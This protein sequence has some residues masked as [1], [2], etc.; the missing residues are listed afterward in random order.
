M[1]KYPPCLF[2]GMSCEFAD[3]R[4]LE[5]W[6]LSIHEHFA[7]LKSGNPCS[8]WI[9]WFACDDAGDV[10]VFT[11]E[12]YGPLPTR[13][14]DK[15]E[16]YISAYLSFIVVAWTAWEQKPNRPVSKFGGMIWDASSGVFQY[17][18]SNGLRSYFH[19]GL[20]RYD[21]VAMPT[22]DSARHKQCDEWFKLESFAREFTIVGK[23]FRDD[24][25][26][27]IDKA[28]SCTGSRPSD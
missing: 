18:L 4:E 12:R 20:Y 8:E 23:R 24:K 26:I 25:H 13:L 27:R 7:G 11:A 21:R 2:T 22:G 3:E 17:E 1:P 15:P 5:E 14:L 9:D 16:A 10:A 19:K 28:F 6:K